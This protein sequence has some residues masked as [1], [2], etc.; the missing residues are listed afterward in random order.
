MRWHPLAP[1]HLTMWR[2]DLERG[3]WFCFCGLNDARSIVIEYL[4]RIEGR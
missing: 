3:E 4:K 1:R 2:V